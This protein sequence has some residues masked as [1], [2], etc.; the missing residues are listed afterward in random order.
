MPLSYFTMSVRSF[1]HCHYVSQPQMNVSLYKSCHSH[2]V[3]PG[4]TSASLGCRERQQR[5]QRRQNRVCNGGP[6]SVFSWSGKQRSLG[7]LLWFRLLCTRGSWRT[8]QSWERGPRSALPFARQ[9]TW[10]AEAGGL[11][12]D[13]NSRPSWV[14]K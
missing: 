14:M 4:C 11:I 13:T 3:L 7:R 8:T 9:A 10:D 1:V 5:A 2:G 6:Q 12:E